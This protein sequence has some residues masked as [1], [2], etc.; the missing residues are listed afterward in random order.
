MS[1][2]LRCVLPLAVLLVL[3]GGCSRGAGPADAGPAE[4]CAP[5]AM[6]CSDPAMKS[7]AVE[8]CNDAGTGWDRAVHCIGRCSDGACDKNPANPY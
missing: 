1:C 7:Q 2:F 6:R 5:A 8:R 4:R 3:G